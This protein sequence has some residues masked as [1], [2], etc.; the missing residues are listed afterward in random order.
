MQK[1]TFIY[2]LKL[3][4]PSKAETLTEDEKCIVSDHF[5][6]LKNLLDKELLILAGRTEGA[7]FGIVIFEAESGSR[8]R[9]IMENDPVIKNGLMIGEIY[10]YRL[11]LWRRH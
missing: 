9:E 7:E 11:A 5:E 2:Q 10:P 8:A 3:T 4:D 6:Y 1:Q